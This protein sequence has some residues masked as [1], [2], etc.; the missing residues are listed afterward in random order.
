MNIFPFN[1]E[2]LESQSVKPNVL[3]VAKIKTW[4]FVGHF[5]FSF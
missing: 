5:E 2:N 1:V 4:N 3:V